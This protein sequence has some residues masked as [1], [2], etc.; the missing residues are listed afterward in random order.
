[1]QNQEVR[2]QLQEINHIF[3]EVVASDDLMVHWGRYLCITVAG[4][5]ELA[6]Q[7]IYQG[8]AD[9]EAGGNLAQYVGSQIAFTVGTPRAD[10]II[11]VAGAFSD[12]WADEVRQFLAQDDRRAA[13]NTVMA[14]RNR[15]AH[16]RQSTI[17]PAQLQAYLVKFVEV[18]DFIENQCLGLAQ[19]NT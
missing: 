4:F 10:N 17:S 12:T 5:L 11:R 9:A 15:I 6:L 7:K 8:Y 14:Q 2:D 1:M 19:P 18:I 16:G 13:I 3:E